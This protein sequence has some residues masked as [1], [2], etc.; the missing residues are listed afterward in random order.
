MRVLIALFS[1]VATAAFSAESE[2]AGAYRYG[3]GTQI[4]QLAL[5]SNGAY[6]AQWDL[7]IAPES[8]RASGT[9]ELDADEVRLTPKKEEGDLRG[10]LTILLVRKIEGRSALLRKEDAEYEENPFF[11]FYRKKDP[12]QPA[13]TTPVSAPH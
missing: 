11:Y 4:I 12:S 2:V 1:L 5:L 8:G 3:D 13:E 6:L 9:W 7:D 10:H